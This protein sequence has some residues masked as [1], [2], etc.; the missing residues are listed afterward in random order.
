MLLLR[1]LALLALLVSAAIHI[2]S[3]LSVELSPVLLFVMTGLTLL[4]WAANLSVGQERSK[5]VRTVFGWRISITTDFPITPKWVRHG[6]GA[7]TLYCLLNVVVLC[8]T[9]PQAENELSPATGFRIFSC[10]WMWFNALCLA[11]ISS[12]LPKSKKKK[13]RTVSDG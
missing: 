3:L 12:A 4:L 1:N 5:T 11:S 8:V 2:M 10:A 6:I 7:L 13:K 9:H